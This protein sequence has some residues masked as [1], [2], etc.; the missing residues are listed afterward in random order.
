MIAFAPRLFCL[1]AFSAR[2]RLRDFA[3]HLRQAFQAGVFW[4]LR[5]Y[6]SRQV[7]CVVRTERVFQHENLF[8]DVASITPHS[9]L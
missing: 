3:M 2:A 8:P 7:A 1:L 4:S 5:R 6:A 9:T